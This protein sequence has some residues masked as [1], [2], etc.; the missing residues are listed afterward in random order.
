MVGLIEKTPI[1]TDVYFKRMIPISFFFCANILLG[2]VSLRYV[3]VSFMQTLKSLT[4]VFAAVLQYLCFGSRLSLQAAVS[5]VPATLGVALSAYTELSFNLVGFFAAILSC[6]FTGLK[7]VLSFA[8][9]RA[10]YNLD[11]INMLL[12]MA[13]PSVLML[14]PSALWFE[15]TGVMAWL[16]APDRT[17]KDLGVLL[18]SAIVSFSLNATLFM[19]IK[20]TSSVTAT[21][22]GNLKTLVVIIISIIIFKNPV[23]LWNYVGMTSA[24]AGITWYGMIKNKWQTTGT[25]EISEGSQ[26]DSEQSKREAA[27]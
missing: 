24:L 12:Y 10:Q 14:L 7:F 25:S 9:L 17:E 11:A 16:K 2:N 23:Q 5:L 1:P 6:L 19:V 21:I 13:P 15:R 3:P 8:L 4:P 27:A 18:F 20:A 26:T 22:A